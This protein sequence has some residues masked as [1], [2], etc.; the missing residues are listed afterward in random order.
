MSLPLTYAPTPSRDRAEVAR[1]DDGFV[2]TIPARLS[3]GFAFKAGIALV[4]AIVLLGTAVWPSNP[5]APFRHAPIP[6]R[7]IFGAVAVYLLYRVI[8]EFI[9]GRGGWAVITVRNSKMIL[10]EQGLFGPT[11]REHW[12]DQYREASTDR[13]ESVG[14]LTLVRVDGSENLLLTDTLCRRADLRFAARELRE[15]IKRVDAEYARQQVAVKVAL[16]ELR[17]SRPDTSLPQSAPH[18]SA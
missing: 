10:T 11:S 1:S 9:G 14:S 18:N 8:H 6:L 3:W 7:F 5:I 16:D 17:E 2:L 15:A 12:L 4:G 13:R